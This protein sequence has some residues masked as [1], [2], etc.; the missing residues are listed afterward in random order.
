MNSTT[1]ANILVVD[2]DPQILK[3]IQAVLEEGGYTVFTADDGVEAIELLE[4]QKSI[5][6]VITDIMMP[7]KEGVGLIRSI[8]RNDKKMK[9]IAM[10]SLTDS[11]A[12]LNTAMAFGADATFKKPFDPRDLINKVD[13]LIS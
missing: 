5:D 13:S 11:E 8:R 1:K 3:L 2:D 12:V 4:L 6:V 7:R 9:I 10:T